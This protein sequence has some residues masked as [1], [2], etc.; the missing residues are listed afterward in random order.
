MNSLLLTLCAD[1]SK[2]SKVGAVQYSPEIELELLLEGIQNHGLL[3]KKG[4]LSNKIPHPCKWNG[5]QCDPSDRMRCIHWSG[6]SLD[7]SIFLRNIPSTVF[8]FQASNCNLY[9]PCSL[10]NISD[11]LQTL[12]LTNNRLSGSMFLTELP[13]E[14]LRLILEN[15]NFTGSV[16]LTQLSPNLEFMNISNNKL[17]GSVELNQLPS[18]ICVIN[19]SGNEFHGSLHIGPIPAPLRSLNCG[20]NS[21]SG[22]L[23]AREIEDGHYGRFVFDDNNFEEEAFFSNVYFRGDGA[24][25][26]RCG[27]KRVVGEGGAKRENF[28][29]YEDE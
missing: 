6:K 28:K 3:Y 21:F 14:L 8:M 11:E 12:E 10:K 25:L 1:T 29:I 24:S 19:L 13:H 20:Q 5:V 23:I 18:S 17:T 22:K 15:N 26:R 9:G 4:F 27:V 16:D 7:G 2:A